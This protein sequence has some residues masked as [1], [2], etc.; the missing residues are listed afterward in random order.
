MSSFKHGARFADEHQLKKA[1]STWLF[2]GK[3]YQ[4]FTVLPWEQ[5]RK[6]RSR[7]V[8]IILFRCVI[9]TDLSGDQQLYYK[10]GL[11]CD[12]ELLKINLQRIVIIKEHAR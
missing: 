11:F 4:H 2:T 6:Y 5:S 7:R 1:L 8:R 3:K 12:A 9:R 10:R